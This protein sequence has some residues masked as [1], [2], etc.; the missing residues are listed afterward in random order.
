MFDTHSTAS[1]KYPASEDVPNDRFSYIN[2][3][4][5]REFELKLYLGQTMV[6]L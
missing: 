6:Y 5:A 1:E 3:V 4:G 2:H